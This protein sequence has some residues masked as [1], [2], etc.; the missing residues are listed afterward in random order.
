MW[1]FLGPSYLFRLDFH[2]CPNSCAVFS[3]LRKEGLST[4]EHAFIHPQHGLHL[5]LNFSIIL[6]KALL[7]QTFIRLLWSLL[8]NQAMT[9][10]H[11]CLSLLCQVLAGIL[12][13]QFRENSP[14]LM[15]GHSWYLVKFLISN[16]HDYFGLPSARILLSLFNQN[17]PYPFSDFLSTD[18]Q[19]VPW[20]YIPT[21]L[22][23]W[24]W[25]Q[26]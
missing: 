4:H 11:P 15:Y 23:I 16:P 12:L 22:C 7:D 1:S 8:L 3:D 10:R 17:P 20:L 9:F 26:F 14:H 24:N 18:P 21:C 19:L 5:L 2:H 6:T 13:S 25:A